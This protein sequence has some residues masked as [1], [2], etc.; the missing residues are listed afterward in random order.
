MRKIAPDMGVG[1]M[2]PETASDYTAEWLYTA[3][4]KGFQHKGNPVPVF[5]EQTYASYICRNCATTST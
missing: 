3:F 1:I 2:L 5:S 4:I